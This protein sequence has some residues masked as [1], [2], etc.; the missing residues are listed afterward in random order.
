MGARDRLA[1]PGEDAADR[2]T[3]P[4]RQRDRDEIEGR[5]QLG[6]AAAGGDRGVEQPGAIEIARH[7]ELARGRADRDGVLLR[8]DDPAAAIVGVLDRDQGRRREHDVTRRLVGGA[9]IVGGEQPALSDSSELHA[10]IGR[11]GARFMP[12]DMRLV[13]EHHL[14]AG[15]RQH[16]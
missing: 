5:G 11:P 10:G 7:P 1:F 16:S 13:T 6:E 8:E 9:K 4:L 15:P 2:A 14:V 12:D 3:Q